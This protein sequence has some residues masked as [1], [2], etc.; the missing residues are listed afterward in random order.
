MKV[1]RLI[2]KPQKAKCQRPTSP[3]A[4][5]INW[6]P[7]PVVVSEEDHSTL[8]NTIPSM[9]SKSS[10]DSPREQSVATTAADP[11]GETMA[12]TMKEAS[13]MNL[14]QTN[15]TKG[16]PQEQMHNREQ[17]AIFTKYSN[18][19]MQERD[20]RIRVLQRAH[21]QPEELR[22]DI[23][24][25]KPKQVSLYNKTHIR[26]YQVTAYE[27]PTDIARQL[28]HV[29]NKI[30]LIDYG[31][32]TTQ[33]IVS[34]SKLVREDRQLAAGDLAVGWDPYCCLRNKGQS[35]PVHKLTL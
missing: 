20:R 7:V 5:L 6:N 8:G 4:N 23:T 9:K 19:I 27:T 2:G 18:I 32:S 3:R 10:K 31:P 15:G 17:E 13:V 21:I 25:V 12:S 16:D 14:T 24:V 11:M 30:S 22:T 33:D 34:N 29:S 28:H 35:R 26:P 1:Q